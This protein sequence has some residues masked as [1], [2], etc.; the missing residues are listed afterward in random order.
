MPPSS[1]RCSTQRSAPCRTA[2]AGW[3][4]DREELRVLTPEAVAR[5][6]GS[7]TGLQQATPRLAGIA[8]STPS[9]HGLTPAAR[10][11]GMFIEW[12][13]AL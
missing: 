4:A 5:R 9:K 10:A 6:D 11:C 7:L 8:V 3:P 13:P 2:A 12:V 1:A